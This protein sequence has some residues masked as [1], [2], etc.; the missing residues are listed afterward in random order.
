MKSGPE[1]GIRIAVDAR[2]LRAAGIGRYLRPIVHGIVAD[3]R[4]EHV[5]L[6]G[7]PNEIVAEVG[8][9]S[10]RSGRVRLVPWHGGAY[11]PRAHLTWMARVQQRVGA[12]D[13]A[14]FPHYDVPPG[15]LPGRV[16]VT[17][18]DLTHFVLPDLVPASKRLPAGALLKRAV[19]RAERVLVGSARTREDLVERIP[20]VQGKIN[21]FRYGLGKE[22][23]GF[24]EA[25]TA[26]PVEGPYLLS[27]GNRKAHKNLG[28]GVRALAGLAREHPQ[29]R[30]V[31]A[32]GS[33]RD[34]WS[35]VLRVAAELGVTDRV[36]D[37]GRIS[38]AELAA[39]YR[40]CV[41][42]LILSFN[43]GFGY[44][45]L[46]AMA[47]GAPVVAA[48]AGALPE[49]VGDAGLLVDPGESAE[50]V[51]AIRRLIKE[52]PFRE[53]LAAAGRERAARF[54]EPEMVRRTLDVLVDAARGAAFSGQPVAARKR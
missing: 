11:S 35:E 30:L 20:E 5:V 41:A 12:A 32:G 19:R 22:I 53:E 2:M 27:V 8:T 42:L 16:V 25:G 54:S 6:A 51:A 4:F 29:L 13:V 44:P 26:P 39:L 9:D 23:A 38:D 24:A 18:H 52:P 43:E 48:R 15:P 47:L 7:D 1:R 34:G 28:M 10:I 40:G 46:E 36:I 3:P 50:V 33:A 17:V 21:G 14:F 31:F 37:L 49:V 45:A